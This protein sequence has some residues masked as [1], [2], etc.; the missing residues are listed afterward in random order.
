M[1]KFLL[2]LAPGDPL[3]L[4]QEFPYFHDSIKLDP[5]LSSE[6]DLCV[7]NIIIGCLFY[8]I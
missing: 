7:H 8:A 4:V 3:A 6:F 1:R 2:N 5:L